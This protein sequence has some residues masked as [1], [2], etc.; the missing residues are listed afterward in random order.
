MGTGFD[1]PIYTVMIFAA[2]AWLSRISWRWIQF[3]FSV[4]TLATFSLTSY[5]HEDLYRCLAMPKVFIR[6]VAGFRPLLDCGAL[7]HESLKQNEFA[8]QNDP[9][10]ILSRDGAV[11]WR[12]L[13]RRVSEYL[14]HEDTNRSPVLL[15]SRHVIANVNSIG[16]EMIK[17]YGFILPMIQIDPGALTST[18][19]SYSRWLSDA[20][21]ASACFALM[22]NEQQGEFFPRADRAAMLLALRNSDFQLVD[23]FD[24]PR[25]GQRFAIWKRN[26]A[27]CRV[28]TIQ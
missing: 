17:K 23:Q 15:L 9:N 25:P 4:L 1:A 12:D 5:A 22:L 7:I 8:P 27:A 18:P 3:V 16:L 13:N 26:V 14:V 10:F 20:P 24:T 2:V 6:G 11:A 19:E 21:Q 28:A